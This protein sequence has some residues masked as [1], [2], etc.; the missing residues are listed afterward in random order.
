MQSQ[1]KAASS[2]EQ[3]WEVSAVCMCQ[4]FEPEVTATRS[5]SLVCV[6]VCVH[7]LVHDQ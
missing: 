4:V 2:I 3:D 6:C 7:V 5:D 1:A